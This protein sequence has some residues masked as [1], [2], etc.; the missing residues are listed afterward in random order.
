MIRL[1]IEDN[2][3][4]SYAHAMGYSGTSDECANANC[5]YGWVKNS[6]SKE[7]HKDR[8]KSSVLREKLVL[9]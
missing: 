6:G 9:A 7:R 3:L 1:S 5:G 2:G 8:K 4:L